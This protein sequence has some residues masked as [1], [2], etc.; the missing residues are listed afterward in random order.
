MPLFCAAAHSEKIHNPHRSCS[1]RILH[2]TIMDNGYVHLTA[3]L[4]HFV[5]GIFLFA[6]S[7]RR[8]MAYHIILVSRLPTCCVGL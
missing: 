7:T 3:A 2:F 8:D 5:I 6:A 4:E 1:I